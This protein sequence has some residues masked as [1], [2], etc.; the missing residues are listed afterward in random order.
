V[1]LALTPG[2]L[3]HPIGYSGPVTAPVDFRGKGMRVPV[4]GVG[5]AL[6]AALGATPVHL[7]PGDSP[8][9]T[10]LL[11]SHRLDVDED[12]V[13]GPP[14]AWFTANETLAAPVATLVANGRSFERLSPDQRQILRTA[15]ADTSR[16]A[17]AVI[18]TDFPEAQ[19]AVKHCD[20]A[21]VLDA[22]ARDVAALEQA[23]RPLYAQVESDPQL[24]TLIAAIQAIKARTPPDPQP[25]LP[26][27]CSR[28][29][30]PTTGAS[31]DPSFLDGTYR[32]RVPHGPGETATLKGGKWFGHGTDGAYEYGTLEVIGNR[33]LFRWAPRWGSSVFTFTFKR[34]ADGTLDLHPVQPMSPDDAHVWA[35][36]PWV[37]V[38][39]P[40]GRLRP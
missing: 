20:V 40:V 9:R 23:T 17:L 16:R 5:D 11:G 14:N 30:A 12:S 27:S 33:I 39:P 38:G 24:R 31:R 1:G 6:A 25:K 10:Q 3:R 8:E 19:G 21:R 35:P 34:G 13:Y 2:L 22:S 4:S 32:W 29:L 26:A 18:L 36:E 28:P 15:A 7:P 37:R